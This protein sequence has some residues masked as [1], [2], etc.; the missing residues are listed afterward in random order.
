MTGFESIIDQKQPTG[1]LRTL[2]RKKNIPHALLFTGIEGVGKYDAAITFAMACNCAGLDSG[3]LSGNEIDYSDINHQDKE[4]TTL[5]L[6]CGCCRACKKIQSDNHPDVLSIRPT[7]SFIKI[8]QIRALYQ[9]LTMKPYEARYRV[10]I[11]AEAH[12]M[13]PAASNAFL[14]V[15]E[16]PPDQTVLILIAEKRSDLLKTVVS[17]CQNIKFNPISRNTLTAML[18]EKEGNSS[19]DAFVLATMSKGSLSKARAMSRMGWIDHRNWL[20]KAIGLD[21][22][23]AMAA[24]PA[25]FLFSVSAQLAENKDTLEDYLEMIKSWLRDLIIFKYQPEKIIH[26]DCATTIK[27]ISKKFTVNALLHKIES[28]QS[29]QLAIQRSNTNAK[30][31]VDILMLKLIDAAN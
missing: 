18:A 22:R 10:V 20:I 7:G 15:L 3:Q 5:G 28:V 12:R 6:P 8:D 25:G 19:E 11:V 2:L 29:T 1:I 31:A 13:N 14:K 27:N 30:L 4:Q 26:Q 21:Q 9:T 24:K 16:E 17:R 23:E